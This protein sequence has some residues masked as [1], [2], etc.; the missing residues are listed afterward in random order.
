MQKLIPIFSGILSIYTLRGTA[1]SYIL[2]DEGLPSAFARVLT[3]PDIVKFGFGLDKHLGLLHGYNVLRGKINSYIDVEQILSAERDWHRT[4]RAELVDGRYIISHKKEAH[5]FFGLEKFLLWATA[6][7]LVAFEGGKKSHQT[8]MRKLE[9]CYP[10]MDNQMNTS[11]SA[12]DFFEKSAYWSLYA[13]II[14]FF[15]QIA[16][17]K[18]CMSIAHFLEDAHFFFHVRMNVK[19]VPL[20]SGNKN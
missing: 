9:K 14:C 10:W 18:K 8:Y 17:G 3:S 16:N 2:K 11:S 15:D 5:R 4:G 19:N 20:E 13:A 1:Y 6:E 12:I 7:D